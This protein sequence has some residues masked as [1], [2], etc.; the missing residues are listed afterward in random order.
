MSNKKEVCQAIRNG[1]KIRKKFRLE[2]LRSE[3]VKIR[4]QKYNSNDG[5]TN[6]GN[7]T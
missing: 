7:T 4:G 5:D 6:I 3:K 2:D 1:H